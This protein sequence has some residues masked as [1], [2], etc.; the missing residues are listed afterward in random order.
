MKL[1]T[2]E[3]VRWEYSAKVP[4]G[5][6]SKENTGSKYQVSFMSIEGEILESLLK[7]NEYVRIHDGLICTVQCT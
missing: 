7:A 5:W 3:Y 4:S 2:V 1:K 6:L